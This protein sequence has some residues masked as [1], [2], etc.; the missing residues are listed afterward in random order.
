MV[1]KGVNYITRTTAYIVHELLKLAC[2]DEN[3]K[4]NV[5]AL[6]KRINKN[7]DPP[8]NYQ[9]VLRQL[10][11]LQKDG[12]VEME[13][14]LLNGRYQKVVRLV[15]DKRVEANTL[16]I[17]YTEKILAGGKKKA[18]RKPASSSKP[19][20]TQVPAKTPSPAA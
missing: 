7:A 12:F 17:E 14:V 15:P 20:A 10:K 6:T 2:E 5:Y 16:L 19:T 4:I 8:V 18:I 11:K 3:E 1:V 9:T 13:E